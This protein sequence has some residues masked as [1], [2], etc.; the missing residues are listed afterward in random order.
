M[1]QPR[2][3]FT[4]FGGTR[5]KSNTASSVV[6]D[7]LAQHRTAAKRALRERQEQI[8][9]W[10]KRRHLTAPNLVWPSIK[11]VLLSVAIGPLVGGV[12]YNWMIW[13]IPFSYIIGAPYALATALVLLIWLHHESVGT[14]RRRFDDVLLGL[15]ASF[16]VAIPIF[17]FYS[18]V[19]LQKSDAVLVALYVAHGVFASAA[20]TPFL[21]SRFRAAR[22]EIMAAYLQ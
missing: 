2:L 22:L 12:F 3:H 13:P 8:K 4:I 9:Q 5:V 1:T 19:N 15:G 17:L 21:A 20:I 6:R 14:T 18:W 7:R 11:L 16:V 10:R